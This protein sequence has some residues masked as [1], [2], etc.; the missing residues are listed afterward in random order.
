[1]MK[2]MKQYLLWAANAPEVP[3]LLFIVLFGGLSVVY[4][5]FPNVLYALIA[6]LCIG[7][8]FIEWQVYATKK[9]ISRA[10]DYGIELQQG[11]TLVLLRVVDR[12]AVDSGQTLWGKKGII[13]C[14][15]PAIEK[16]IFCVEI[17]IEHP[18]KTDLRLKVNLRFR[19]KTKLDGLKG[20]IISGFYAEDLARASAW[21]W[22]PELTRQ[23]EA[24]FIRHFEKSPA[25]RESLRTMSTTPP[26]DTLKEFEKAIR[27]SN[28]VLNLGFR[29]VVGM[30][31]SLTTEVTQYIILLPN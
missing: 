8:L 1:M 14:V 25:V 13:P 2:F 4:L 26:V 20:T 9:Y 23:I 28:F 27:S 21:N 16:G 3:G 6:S 19:L 5:P 31:L 22:K 24:L 18:Y 7:I 11:E 12:K 30:G 17:L 29:N 15:L 10:S